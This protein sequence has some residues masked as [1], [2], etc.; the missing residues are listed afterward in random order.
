MNNFINPEKKYT[1][2]SEWNPRKLSRKLIQD[3]ELLEQLIREDH[4]FEEDVQKRLF[5]K[6]PRFIMMLTAKEDTYGI[7]IDVLHQF[8]REDAKYFDYIW[9]AEVR[10]RLQGTAITEK[11]T[12][13]SINGFSD[14]SS[15]RR[16]L[17]SGGPFISQPWVVADVD[18]E[19]SLSY[20][21]CA[22]LFKD[23]RGK[24]EIIHPV[25]YRQG[26]ALRHRWP[27]DIVPGD[28]PIRGG[29]YAEKI[30]KIQ[31]PLLDLLKSGVGIKPF[32][33]RR[34]AE[35]FPEL[36]V[37]PNC[38]DRFDTKIFH[39]VLKEFPFLGHYLADCYKER[40]NEVCDQI[41]EF[42]PNFILEA[43]FAY[44]MRRKKMVKVSTVTL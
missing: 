41:R 36:I 12:N 13:T 30:S 43:P 25:T 14:T 39:N 18:L 10:E 17:F 28:V 40:F 2:K 3:P 44:R 9:N 22:S 26:V 38:V 23:F 37:H 21:K 33:L 16:R 15:P 32:D 29:D 35:C 27:H 5:K 31:Y 7:N 19:T 24:S 42:D 4:R 6:D 8:I 1:G 20:R 11:F 34:S